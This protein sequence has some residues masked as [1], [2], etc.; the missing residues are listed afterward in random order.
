MKRKPSSILPLEHF[1]EEW[2]DDEP[3]DNNSQS[4]EEVSLPPANDEQTLLDYLKN[5]VEK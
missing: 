3:Q 5:G 1:V 2:V 4:M